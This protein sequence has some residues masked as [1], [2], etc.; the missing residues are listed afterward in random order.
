MLTKCQNCNKEFKTYP[1]K[2]KTGRGKFC[3]KACSYPNL[4]GGFT[5]GH[6]YLPMSPEMRK[7]TNEKLKGK[8]SWNKDMKM[9][10]EYCK[11][12]SLSSSHR[13][14]TEEE[15]IKM[16][17]RM[18][19]ICGLLKSKSKEHI[20]QTVSFWKGKKRPDVSLRQMGSKNPMYGKTHIGWWKGK[21][22][23]KETREKMSS[24]YM[25][26]KN[27]FWMGG[28]SY[29]IYPEG[30]TKMFKESI[31]MRD[32]FTCYICKEVENG[33]AHHVHH[34]D[35]NKKNC[36]PKNLITLCRRCHLKT[37]AQTIRVQWGTN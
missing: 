15:K 4:V 25:G 7:K 6:K 20:C 22:F 17:E 2:L 28:V 3:S 27:R 12:L 24:N 30:W 18:C 37:N 13:K 14:L 26:E 33:V 21:K 10:E 23:S 32:S 34:I 29:E 11:K 35:Y 19:K 16:R 36:D 9:S 8:V 1:C 31:K 5:D